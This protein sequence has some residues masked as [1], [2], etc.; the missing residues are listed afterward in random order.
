MAGNRRRLQEGS[1]LKNQER[2]PTFTRLRGVSHFKLPLGRCHS[3]E[4]SQLHCRL[5]R[6]SGALST[7]RDT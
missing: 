7:S 2:W 3:T 6:Y 4:V 1:G 5:S